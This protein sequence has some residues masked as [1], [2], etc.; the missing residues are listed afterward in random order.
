MKEDGGGSGGGGGGTGG[1]EGHCRCWGEGGCRRR[2]IAV[3]RRWTTGPI[4]GDLGIA[5]RR[6][7]RLVA[8]GQSEDDDP[9]GEIFALWGQSTLLTAVRGGETPAQRTMTTMTRKRTSASSPTEA[10]AMTAIARCSTAGG[11]A[12]TRGGPGDDDGDVEAPAV[13]VTDC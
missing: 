6:A 8:N 3:Q 7:R 12:T 2:R 11:V 13:R 10:A 5:A 9:G 1:E 4:A